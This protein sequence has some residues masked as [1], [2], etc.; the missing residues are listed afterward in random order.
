MPTAPPDASPPQAAALAERIQAVLGPAA[1]PLTFAQVKSA[2]KQAGV[3]FTGRAK[4]TDEQIQRELEA[5]GIHLH[6]PSTAKG[7][8]KYWHRPPQTLAEQV[9]ATVQA[10]LDA[11]GDKLA[12]PSQLGR[13]KSP[14]GVRTFDA[15]LTRL[16]DDGKL[17]R[18][19]AKYTTQEP[20][21]PKW[22]ESAPHKATYKKLADAAG[23]LVDAGGVTLDQIVT[24]LRE[25]FGGAQPVVPQS[26]PAAV[27]PDVPP[28]PVA[29][30]A[31]GVVAPDLGAALRAAYDHLCKFA[32]FKDRLVELPRLYHETRKR[33]PSMSVG[34]FH[35]ELTRLSLAYRIELH[36]LNEVGTAEEPHLAISR[37]DRLYYYARWK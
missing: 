23:K 5:G 26:P 2:L 25:K 30:P 3:L 19:G 11:L 34:A 33:L 14:E 17:F 31:A 15:I 1:A 10:K 36:V 32:E 37:N 29:P 22:Y 27:P 7:K 16:L 21:R 8:P 6:P 24:A 4:V 9:E 28:P 20:P 35:E 18:R 12:T 13:P